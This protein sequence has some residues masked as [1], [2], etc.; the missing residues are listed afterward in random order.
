MATKR[1]PV[2]K[3]QNNHKKEVGI[4][5]WAVALTDLTMFFGRTWKT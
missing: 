1:N 5:E 4:I 2:L 3:K